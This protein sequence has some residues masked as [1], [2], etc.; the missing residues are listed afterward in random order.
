MTESDFGMTPDTADDNPVNTFPPNVFP[1]GA[2]VTVAYGSNERPFCTL[3]NLY[4]ILGYL[5]G[6][7]PGADDINSVIAE[8]RHHVTH[9]LPTDMRT[10]NPPP[11]PGDDVAD[12]HWLGT[13]IGKYGPR[14]ALTA[15]PGS[16]NNPTASDTTEGSTDA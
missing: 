5:T 6:E 9:Q 16:L 1:L 15:M 3:G 10:E 7:V 4:R 8:C 11:P 13:V 14:I 12:I 2:A